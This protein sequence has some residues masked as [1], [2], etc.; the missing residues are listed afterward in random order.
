MVCNV[1][2]KTLAHERVMAGYDQ[3]GMACQTFK[4]HEPIEH[5]LQVN[6]NRERLARAQVF[7]IMRGI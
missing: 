7:P 3:V 1:L 6:D 2:R 5:V 4:R